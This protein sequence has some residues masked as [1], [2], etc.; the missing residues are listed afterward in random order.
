[1]VPRRSHWGYFKGWRGEMRWRRIARAA[2]ITMGL[3]CGIGSSVTLLNYLEGREQQE[4]SRWPTTVG[5]ILSTT[6]ETRGTS[7]D[8]EYTVVAV[9]SNYTVDGTSYLCSEDFDVKT[10]SQ[11]RAGTAVTVHYSPS[12]PGISFIDAG[13]FIGR[14]TWIGAAFS[15]V[16]IAALGACVY[17][18][19]WWAWRKE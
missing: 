8:N 19:G 7:S 4:L 5:T 15:Y 13:R 18:W 10:G 11:F 9:R 17:I 6:Q 2:T 1:M 16:L 12:K 14:V 3:I